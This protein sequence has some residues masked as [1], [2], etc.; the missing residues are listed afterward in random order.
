MVKK[1]FLIGEAAK[2]CS[3]SVKQIRNWQEL[4][5]LKDGPRI[6]CGERSYRQFDEDDLTMIRRIKDYLNQGFTL[7]AASQKASNEIL[8]GGKDNAQK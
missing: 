5:H 7:K 4:G 3:V 6:I 1:N 2:L 8:Q